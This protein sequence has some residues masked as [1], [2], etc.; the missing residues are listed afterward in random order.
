MTISLLRIG[1]ILVGLAW[2]SLCA[3]QSPTPQVLDVLER[4]V[5]ALTGERSPEIDD[6]NEPE[7]KNAGPNTVTKPDA[8]GVR[9]VPQ[10]TLSGEL[11]VRDG[12]HDSDP[13]QATDHSDRSPERHALRLIEA[14]VKGGDWTQ[15]LGL[16]AM[17]QVL[18]TGV[19][20]WLIWKTV[21]YT[22][23][24]SEAAATAAQAS[25]EAVAATLDAIEVTRDAAM[26]ELRAYVVMHSMSLNRTGDEVRGF[27]A[28][29]EIV[30]KNVGKTPAYKTRF[31]YGINDDGEPPDFAQM[32]ELDDDKR[33]DFGP[34][35]HLRQAFTSRLL[36]ANL[37]RSVFN[38]SVPLYVWGTVTY[39]D[40]Y[41]NDRYLNFRMEFKNGRFLNTNTGNDSN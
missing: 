24:A 21:G 36:S 2:S 28:A 33:M 9:M 23:D 40:A 7:P 15:Y 30:F 8:T 14:Q 10:I 41:N 34:E 19:G 32:K 22:K 17:L 29:I 39:V 20:L 4:P 26:R 6:D 5:E 38:G 25:Q 37:Q 13:G 1:C 16:I 11:K 12:Q 27:T 35:Q 31:V 3:S 18:L